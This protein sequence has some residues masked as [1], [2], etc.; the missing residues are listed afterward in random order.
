[1]NVAGLQETTLDAE[2]YRPRDYRGG[3][4]CSR[5]SIITFQRRFCWFQSLHGLDGIVNVE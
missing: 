3:W 4:F 2:N 5:I 1:M